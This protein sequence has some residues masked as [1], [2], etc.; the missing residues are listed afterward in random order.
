MYNLNFSRNNAYLL[1]I[2][3]EALEK[4]RVR[5]KLR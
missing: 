3:K 2:A 5:E 1:Q 4:L